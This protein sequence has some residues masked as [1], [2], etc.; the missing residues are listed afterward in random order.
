MTNYQ[1]GAVQQ[2][3]SALIDGGI[4]GVIGT[5]AMSA[6]MMAARKTGIMGRQPPEKLVEKGLDRIGVDRTR[7]TQ[8]ALAVVLH[9]GFGAA[10]GAFFG[11]AYRR[12]H[13][14]I[15]AAPAGIIFGSLVWAVSYK[16]WIPALGV[17]PPPERDQPGRQQTMILAHL[18]YGS[19]LGSSL[20]VAASLRR[21]ITREAT[22]S[23]A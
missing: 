14:S 21:K 5:A 13:P 17:L 1:G 11:L 2:D 6:V 23:T 12:L 22:Q 9:F 3:V 18:V 7:E 8:D 20:D 10:M 16:G 19:T 15:D 4:G